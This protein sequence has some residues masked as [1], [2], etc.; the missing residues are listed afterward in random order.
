VVVATSEEIQSGTVARPNDS[1]DDKATIRFDETLTVDAS[2]SEYVPE[3]VDAILASAS[4]HGA[5]DVHLVP[6][7]NAL[8][9]SWRLNGVLQTVASFPN[10]LKANIVARLKVLA[11]LLT[12]RRLLSESIDRET[13]QQVGNRADGKLIPKF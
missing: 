8:E 3:L 9:M 5:S 7:E 12:Y 6:S 4:D 1:P 10:A 11:E 2:D 13:F